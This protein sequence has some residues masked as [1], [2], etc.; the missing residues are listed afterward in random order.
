MPLW[1][2]LIVI[3]IILAIVGFA[4]VVWRFRNEG[5]RAAFA[6]DPEVYTPRFGGYDP[7]GVARGVAAPGFPQLWVRRNDRLYLFHK[8]ET[9]AAFESDPQAAVA[10]ALTS[11][12]SSGQV[13]GQVNKLKLVKRGMFG[14]AGFAFL[15]RRF[16]L[17]G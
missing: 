11:E 15:R 13:E 1:L 8:P 7:L 10:A 16:L 17:A 4:G 2:I 12:W 9:R 14:R 5:N 3:G 6:A